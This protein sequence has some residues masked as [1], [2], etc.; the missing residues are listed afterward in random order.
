MQACY[1]TQLPS[2]LLPDEQFIS[3]DS[4]DVQRL[5]HEVHNQ[6]NLDY[7]L[8]LNRQLHVTLRQKQEEISALREKNAQLKELARQTQHYAS[9]LEALT[10]SAEECSTL[11]HSQSVDQA[12]S[13]PAHREQTD[14]QSSAPKPCEKTDWLSLVLSHTEQSDGLYTDPSDHPGTKTPHTNNSVKRLFQGVI[15]DSSDT[16]DGGGDGEKISMSPKRDTK[17]PKLDPELFQLDLEQLNQITEQAERDPVQS[18]C[19]ALVNQQ[20]QNGAHSSTGQ[21][22][23]NV[24]LCGSLH[25]LNVV[26]ATSPINS[27]YTECTGSGTGM[28]FKT[29]IR[30]HST[31][32]TQVFPNGR[33]FTS[34]TPNGGCRFLWIPTQN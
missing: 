8:K 28:C 9:I 15:S 7:A 12:L 33:T 18:D 1:Y 19:N 30:D 26:T 17:R 31:V 2:C 5:G 14:L 16:S 22:T 20:D 29:S 32:R 3:V 6:Q 23:V 4:S 10:P 21:S 25:G 13:H 34:H 27:G 11:S 24:N